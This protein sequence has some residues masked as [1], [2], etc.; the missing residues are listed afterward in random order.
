MALT[1]RY[2]GMSVSSHLILQL[3]I[4]LSSLGEPNIADVIEL[5]YDGINCERSSQCYAAD[6]IEQSYSKRCGAESLMD[7][8]E[9]IYH[10][11]KAL[12]DN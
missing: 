10:F 8:S 7:H 3:M 5:L 11:I 2:C 4:N 12:V 1:L 9:L 6:S